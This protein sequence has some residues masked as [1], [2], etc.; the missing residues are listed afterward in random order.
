[1]AY[2]TGLG[3]GLARRVLRCVALRVSP[4]AASAVGLRALAVAA[5]YALARQ[6]PQRCGT[7]SGLAAAGR[8]ATRYFTCALYVAGC[9]ATTSTCAGSEGDAPVDVETAVEEPQVS[10]ERDGDA[11][12][13]SEHDATAGDRRE[14]EEQ[15]SQACSACA[16]ARAAYS[17]LADASAPPQEPEPEIIEEDSD[18]EP[19]WSNAH[20]H[21]LPINQRKK[22]NVFKFVRRDLQ[23][24][25]RHARS[26][27][28]PRPLGVLAYVG[29]P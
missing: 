9:L 19:F 16:A 29:H 6:L 4:T 2:G 25:S 8:R 5:P 13:L 24:P 1:M 11:E 28:R 3:F 20:E 22:S 15:V 10:N 14:N 7:A 12:E 21:R 23:H 18:G 17:R 27:L 26:L